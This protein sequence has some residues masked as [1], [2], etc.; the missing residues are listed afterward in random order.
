MYG[1]THVLRLEA[2]QIKL[3]KPPLPPKTNKLFGNPDQVSTE[4]QGPIHSRAKIQVGAVFLGIRR[5]LGVRLG[6]MPTTP[7]SPTPSEA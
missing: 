7:P 5:L 6:I 2:L 3:C 1:I 4:L